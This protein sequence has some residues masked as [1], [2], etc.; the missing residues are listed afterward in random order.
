MA[1]KAGCLVRFVC[2]AASVSYGASSFPSTICR[3]ECRA[4]WCVL[5]PCVLNS[6][7]PSVWVE[8]WSLCPVP[9]VPVPVLSQ[10][11]TVLVTVA[12]QQSVTSGRELPPA[13]SLFSGFLWLFGVLCGSP[14]ILGGFA[15]FWGK[16]PWNFG[17]DCI[18][19]VHCFG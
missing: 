7:T 11:H 2:R 12:S 1:W 16:I 9:L 10:F 13:R 15:L 3:G 14:Q 5:G 17:R 18:H 6:P 4:P 19:C 8:F